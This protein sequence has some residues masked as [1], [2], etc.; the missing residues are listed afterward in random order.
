MDFKRKIEST[1]YKE[2]K[3]QIGTG[4]HL[5]RAVKFNHSLCLGPA[6][7]ERAKNLMKEL[8]IRPRKENTTAL[9][10]IIA[11]LLFTKKPLIVSMTEKEWAR[12]KY[13]RSGACSI[14]LINRLK[15]KGLIEM[16]RGIYFDNLK[17]KT[18]IWASDRFM[19]TF[20][21]FPNQ[22]F[23]D[24][25]NLV[26]LKGDDGELIEYDETAETRRIKRI[27]KHA[28][29]VNEQA[30]IRFGK[31]VLH[32]HLVAKFKRK[33]TLYGR[34]HTMGARHYQGYGKDERLRFTINGDPVI[35]IDYS[36]LHP[37]LLY[38]A[39]G[40]QSWQD[41]YS[42]IADDPDEQTR[43]LLR[44]ALKQ[45]L[46]ALIN[47]KG[48]WTKPKQKGRGY[49]KRW[50]KA[51]TIALK[52]INKII[53]YDRM[54]YVQCKKKGLDITPTKQ[55]KMLE[56]EL[57]R[58][59]LAQKG[60]TKARHLMEAFRKA[61]PKIA[62]RFCTGDVGMKLMNKDSKIALDIVQHFT[63]QGIPILCV[64]DSFIVQEQHQDELENMMLQTYK[65]H[66]GGFR[67]RVKKCKTS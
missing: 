24:P 27:L 41:P 65:K 56:A 62:H 51:E 7:R 55:R 47:G 4:T 18:R 63:N 61:H 59:A 34:L 67:I 60:R 23:I 14:N 17:R 43:D 1:A 49:K 15:E 25:V 8:E 64:H 48:K 45:A 44:R 5:N 35:E 39:E 12:S 21:K 46:L 40:L 6:D 66:T 31:Y 13:T 42:E 53:W 16:K 58:D 54:T 19:D 29:K 11:N 38:A 9:E 37:N 52:A 3:K 2:W 36:G 10:N 20:P 57:M 30:S 26:E 28:N 22:V 50:I 33:F 32:G